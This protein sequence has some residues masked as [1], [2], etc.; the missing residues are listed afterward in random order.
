MF[1]CRRYNPNVSF[2]SLRLTPSLSSELLLSIHLSTDNSHCDWLQ[3]RKSDSGSD[4][5][6]PPSPLRTVPVTRRVV[7]SGTETEDDVDSHHKQSAKP[8][9]KIGPEGGPVTRFLSPC[10]EKALSAESSWSEQ[11]WDS[12]QVCGADC[13]K[14]CLAFSILGKSVTQT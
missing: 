1:S 3:G 4:G 10:S 13:V 8:K 5:R 11:A 7:S 6:D 2:D 12:F 9:F 14:T